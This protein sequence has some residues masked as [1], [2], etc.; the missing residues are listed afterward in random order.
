MPATISLGIVGQVAKAADIG[1]VSYLLRQT[2][3]HVLNDGTTDGAFDKVYADTFSIAASGSSSLDLAGSM[4]D[5]FGTAFTPVEIAAILVFADA[6]N[7]NNIVVGN[8]TNHVP[9]FS[10]ATASIAVR[11]GSLFCITAGGTGIAVTASTG[12]ILKLTNSAGTT[13]VTGGIIILGR[14]A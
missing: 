14:S 6:T 7:T 1:E 10:A 9:I 8:D 13:A 4:T 3:S 11:P 12:D 5:I 2:Y